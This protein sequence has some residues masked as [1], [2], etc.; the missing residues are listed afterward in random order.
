MA[1][2][3]LIALALLAVSVVDAHAQAS[4]PRGRARVAGVVLD[5]GTGAPVIRTRI[6]AEAV[7]ELA[8]GRRVRCSA[9]D[10][11]GHY[12]LDSLA[13]GTQT[14][15]YWCSGRR[16][17]AGK[18]LARDTLVIADGQQLRRDVRADA[19]GC[20]MRAFTVREAVFEGRYT[21]GFESSAF[22]SCGDSVAAWVTFSPASGRARPKWPKPN[23]KY[24]PGYFVRWH[25][26][27]RGPWS[28]GHLGGSAYELVV[29]SILSVR[30]PGRSDCR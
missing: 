30:L 26:T 11:L 3:F 28:Y 29:D 18:V 20:D 24:N 13:A 16:A 21:S 19:G 8:N 14:V 2:A 6:C 27:L 5:G 25:G 4:A 1:R 12:V 23:D 10:T 22:L 7:P 17:S 15:T 9:P